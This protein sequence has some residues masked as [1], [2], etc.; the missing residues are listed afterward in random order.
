[1]MPHVTA[2][3]EDHSIQ[4]LKIKGKIVWKEGIY[5]KKQKLK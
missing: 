2:K 5:I 4:L 3:L 1:M